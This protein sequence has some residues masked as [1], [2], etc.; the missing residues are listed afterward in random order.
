[1]L[2]HA[3][4]NNNITTL[5]ATSRQNPSV[6][7]P[8]GPRWLRWVLI[9]Y[10]LL[11]IPWVVYLL[12]FQDRT[13]TAHHTHLVA[14]GLAVGA[15]VLS[16]VTAMV[17]F[18]GKPWV[19]IAATMTATWLMA[20]VFFA[21]VLTHV[22]VTY[23]SLPGILAGVV[24]ALRVLSTNRRPH[25]LWG[26]VLI[27]VAA[28]LLLHL[29]LL[30]TNTS[31]SFHAD[32]LRLLIVVYDSAEVA[33][34][35]GLGLCLRS[36]AARAAIVFGAAG[37]VLFLLDAWVNVTIVSGEQDF[38]A[39]LVYAIVGEIP[40]IAMCAGGTWLALHRWYEQISPP[41]KMST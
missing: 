20:G 31:T 11:E 17:V 37:V 23:A 8:I 36:G 28:A 29:V 41:V 5:R 14:T 32:H 21:L 13:G 6:L 3:D 25:P 24:V 15:A 2:R 38:R 34:L 16:L 4:E 10:G 27:L 40:S 18:R 35:L 33:S 39:A 9:A 7:T 30:Y 1:M 19:V 12:F 26:W 22:A